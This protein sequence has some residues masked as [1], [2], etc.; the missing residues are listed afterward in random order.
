MQIEPMSKTPESLES[1]PQNHTFGQKGTE[2]FSRTNEDVFP[3]I[4]LSRTLTIDPQ[5]NE[6]MFVNA[7]APAEALG[8][9]G[10]SL[11]RPQEVEAYYATKNTLDNSIGS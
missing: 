7:Q 8:L 2:E 5:N 3:S 4:P 11:A 6:L 9:V 10:V 1:K